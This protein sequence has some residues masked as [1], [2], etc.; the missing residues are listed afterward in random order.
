MENLRY[1]RLEATDEK[2]IKAA[3]K[4]HAHEFI[5][6]LP[7]SYELLVGE[8]VVKLSGAGSLNVSQ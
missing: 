2:V 3:K 5:I 6:K 8:R 7:Q 1:R 4:A